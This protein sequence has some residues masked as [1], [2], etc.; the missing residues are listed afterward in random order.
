MVAITIGI[1]AAPASAQ[2]ARDILTQASFAARSK[3]A[4][5][6][7]IAE[8]ERLAAAALARAPEDREA[9]LMQATARSYRAKVNGSRADAIA[10]RTALDRSPPRSMTSATSSRRHPT[11]SPAGRASAM[12]AVTIG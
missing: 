9:L 6:Q 4:A 3:A 5:L 1:A 12:A 7:G 11:T 2:S 8:A 10:A